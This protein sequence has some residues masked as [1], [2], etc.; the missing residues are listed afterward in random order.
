MKRL[1]KHS[2][3]LLTINIKFLHSHFSNEKRKSSW[4]KEWIIG[5]NIFLSKT[6]EKLSLGKL[7]S[8]N[9][10]ESPLGLVASKLNSEYNH[11]MS[12][13]IWDFLRHFLKAIELRIS[14]AIVTLL[15]L[16]YPSSGGTFHSFIQGRRAINHQITDHQN[17]NCLQT[18][19]IAKGAI[20][21]LA[22]FTWPTWPL[23]SRVHQRNFVG[24]Y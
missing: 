15:L 11:C 20:L 7:F 4:A 16:L 12:R 21:R 6:V 24:L 8:Q 2:T 22:L 1:V 19:W 14:N 13:V 17:I 5:R 23:F 18:Q 10:T 9:N 3:I